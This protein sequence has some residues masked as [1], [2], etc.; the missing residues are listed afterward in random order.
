MCVSP[1]FLVHVCVLLCMLTKKGAPFWYYGDTF[2]VPRSGCAISLNLMST[3]IERVAFAT[4]ISQF[5]WPRP[6][7]IAGDQAAHSP[8]I[9]AVDYVVD[10]GIT[11]TQGKLA[12]AVALYLNC[13]HLIPNNTM[14]VAH[15]F[16]VT[17]P[18]HL[19]STSLC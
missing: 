12:V 19:G 15:M 7:R 3:S 2:R 9:L 6:H 10:V 18:M 1:L 8:A 5:T 13:P 14:E 4:A 16:K 11:P 17:G